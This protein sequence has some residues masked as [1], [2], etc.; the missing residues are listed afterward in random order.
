MRLTE[1]LRQSAATGKSEAVSFS[2]FDALPAP[3]A[4]YF[5]FA[6]REGRP[7]IRFARIRHSGEFNLNGKWIPFESEQHFS[8]TPPAFVWDAKMRLN[9]LMNVRVRDCYLDG[10]GSML[11]KILALFT[12][13]DAKSDDKLDAGALQRYLAEAVWLPTAL[14]PN[15]NLR[16][17]T[18]D[19]LHA[20]ATLTDGQT[21]VSLEFSF[22]ESGRVIGIFAPTRFRE[23]KGKYEPLP[24]A[25]RFWNYGER[26]GMMIPLEGEVEWLLPASTDRYW[27][28]RIVDVVYELAQ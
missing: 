24:W 7:H 28:G 10:H 15:D 8:S 5:R 14:L 19:D 4:K 21:T 16:W 26:S 6:L 2:D 13:M 20:L 3:V 12:V 22:D 1:R 25:G 11:A 18:I 23:V 17:D 27:K 9:G